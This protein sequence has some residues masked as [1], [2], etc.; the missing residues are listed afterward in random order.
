MSKAEE[1][2]EILWSDLV[3]R[4]DADSVDLDIQQEWKVEWI[5]LLSAFLQE[6]QP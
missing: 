5:A 6:P 4:L 3:D 2:W 1:L